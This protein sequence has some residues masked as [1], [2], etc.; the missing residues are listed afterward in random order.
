MIWAF[1]WAAACRGPVVAKG[2]APSTREATRIV[3][4][5]DLHA[6]FEQASR[7]LHAVGVIDEANHWT[8]GR[9]VLV[10]TGDVMDRGAD[11]HR[12]IR[13]LAALQ[14]EAREAGGDVVPLLGNHEVMNL[15]GDWRYVEPSDIAQYGGHAERRRALAPDGLDGRFLRSLDTVARIDGTI[16]VHGGIH[17]DFADQPIEETNARIR[18]AID[19]PRAPLPVLGERGPLWYR[20]YLLEPESVACA[21]LDEALTRLDARRMVVGHTTQR[22]GVLRTRCAGRLFAIDVGIAGPYGHHG[23]VL[24]IVGD[25]S[26]ALYVDSNGTVRREPLEP[27]DTSPSGGGA[28]SGEVHDEVGRRSSTVPV[29]R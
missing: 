12:I 9:T 5:G 28:G 25:A 6:D 3:A 1:L 21:R 7:V 29:E 16:F 20:G 10:Q 4:V 23:G 22:N 24:E 8:G 2:G 15:R 14:I 11:S 27:R 13:F 18:A 26:S 19:E 17:P